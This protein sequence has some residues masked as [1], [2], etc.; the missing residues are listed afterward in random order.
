MTSL[1][2]V[3]AEVVLVLTFAFIV[4]ELAVGRDE[5][6]IEVTY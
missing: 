5:V 3:H 4:G 2:T 1:S 6:R